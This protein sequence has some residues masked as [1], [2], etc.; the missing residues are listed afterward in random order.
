MHILTW[1]LKELKEKNQKEHFF[2]T[3][4]NKFI[5]LHA[6]CHAALPPTPNP[7]DTDAWREWYFWNPCIL[8]AAK[9][10]STLIRKQPVIPVVWS[11]IFYAVSCIVMLHWDLTQWLHCT[12]EIR[13]SSQYSSIDSSFLVRRRFIFKQENSLVGCILPACQWLHWTSEIRYSSP[14]TVQ[15]IRLFFSKDFL[16]LNYE[17]RNGKDEW[18]GEAPGL[19]IKYQ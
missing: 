7:P 11:Y 17:G 9:H 4:I 2:G 16:S 12:S 10:G 5:T 8:R 14:N 15:S 1:M 6:I 18:P 19:L 3:S 13:Y